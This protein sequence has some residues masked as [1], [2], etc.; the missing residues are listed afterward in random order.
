MNNQNKLFN[1]KSKKY[2]LLLVNPEFKYHHYGTQIELTKILGKP[3]FNYSLALPTVAALTPDNYDVKIIDEE[4]NPIPYDCKPD[5]VGITCVFAT[6]RSAYNIANKFKSKG[7][8]VVMGGS[9]AT[10]NSKEALLH[11][12]SVVIGEAEGIWEECLRDFE[13]GI[14]KKTYKAKEL[15]NFK[16]SPIPRWDLIDTNKINSILVQVSRGCPYECEFCL[17]TKMY[18]RNRRLRD[19]DNVIEEIKASPVKRVFFVDDNLTFNKKYARELMK[20]LK[21]LKITWFCQSSIELADDIELLKEMAEAGCISLLIGFESLNQKNIKEIKKHQNVIQNYEKALKNI[22]SAGIHVMASFLVGFDSDTL[23]TFDR[24]FEFTVK[25]NLVFAV[26]SILSAVPGTELYDRI[27]R[28]KRLLDVD[29]EFCNGMFTTIKTK[30][31]KPITILDNYYRTI[32]RLLDPEIMLQKAVNLL[33]S[34][35]FKKAGGAATGVGFFEKVSSSIFLLKRFYFTKNEKVKAL[36]KE[37]VSLGVNKVAAW[38]QIAYLLLSIAGFENYI[39]N[40]THYPDE[41]RSKI[42]KYK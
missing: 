23:D 16:T 40:T 9:Y 42:M 20:R 6:S 28:E 41:I 33:K 5:L 1:D 36:F 21:P 18:G 14:L 13:K 17:V 15:T 11:A 27:K 34:G 12:D 35:G 19:I 26:F 30:N 8:P 31:M 3:S 38:E 29:P 37:I 24:I 39:K 2:K 22:H 25:N 7:I 4:I 32:K 10:F